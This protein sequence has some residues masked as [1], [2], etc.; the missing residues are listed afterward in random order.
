ME[1]QS[2]KSYGV[3]DWFA[4]KVAQEVRRNISM[5][6]V[7]AIMKESEKAVYAMLNLGCDFS[8]C[9]WIPKSVLVEREIGESENGSWNHETYIESNFDKCR[10]M[11][12]DHW[13]VYR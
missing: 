11:F 7:F 12:K 4:N 8:N 6:D 5:C 1:I 10:E 9:I 3:K 2:G 13:D